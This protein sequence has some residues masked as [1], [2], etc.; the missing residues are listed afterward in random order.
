MPRSDAVWGIDIGQCA[1]KALRC[2]PHEDPHRV[3]ALAFDYIEFPKMLNQPDVDPAELIQDALAQFL[4]RNGVRGDRVVISVS[5]QSGLARFIKLPPVEAKKIPDIVRY[6]ARQQIPFALT[7]VVWDYQQMVG[8]TVVEG[9][10]M[11]TEVGL[12]A[13]K[14]DQVYRALKPF[15]AAGIEVDIVQLAPLALYNYVVFDQMPKLPPPDEYDADNPPESIVL[16]SLGT[17][18]TDLVITNGYRMWQRSIP[19]GG[20]HFTK[21]LTKELKLTFATAEHLKRNAAQ[22]EDPRALFQ[23]M[24]PVFND[25]LTEVQRSIGYFTNLHRKEKIGRCLALGNAMKLPGLQRYLSQNLGMDLERVEGYRCLSGTSVTEAPAFKENVMSFGVSYGLCLQALR[26]TRIRTNLLPREIL[27]DRL[28]RSK[29]PWA[30]GAAAALLLSLILSYFFH[31]RAWNAVVVPNYW[32]PA[33]AEADRVVAKANGYKTEYE[34]AREAYKK[35]DTAGLYLIQNLEGRELWIELLKALNECL[36][37][38]PAGENL[39]FE[40]RREIKITRIECQRLTNLNEWWNTVKDVYHESKR[41]KE[42]VAA[43]QPAAPAVDEPEKRAEVLTPGDM[44]RAV[45][46]EGLMGKDEPPAAEPAQTTETPPAAPQVP[47]PSGPGW[48]FQITGYHYHNPRDDPS[49]Q[50]ADY[51]RKTLIAN[52]EQPEV[53]GIDVGRLGIGYPVLV[54]V[55][56]IDFN[57]QLE[58]PESEFTGEGAN[59]ALASLQAAPGS[60][61]PNADGK[62]R[63]RVARFDF[64]LQFCWVETPRHKRGG[65]SAPAVAAVANAPAPVPLGN[66]NAANP[67]PNA[68]TA[69]DGDDDADASTDEAA[70]EGLPDTVAGDAAP[71][72]ETSDD[73]APDDAAETDLAPDASDDA[74]DGEADGEADDEADGEA[75]DEADSEASD[76]ASPAQA[77]ADEEAE[78][79]PPAQPVPDDEAPE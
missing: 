37:R 66:P 14:R 31:W 74:A 4:S 41:T 79:G 24:R 58:V 35:V 26:E 28:I 47:G 76:D 7:D 44:K 43:L 61:G 25:L 38:S 20:S 27:Q 63:V 62:R 22:A 18:T 29:K 12:F 13:M 10:V 78:A 70:G 36:P 3:V 72:A 8:G 45:G 33:A 50:G 51:V 65:A 16:L 6:E 40:R 64:V 73:S 55:P 56:N 60:G 49:N 21:A 9:F 15:T 68:A 23:A 46:A 53:N 59:P 5:G 2:R 39:P 67:A 54:H 77:A 48:V 30:V 32:E 19:L 52:L 34:Q 75:D 57:Y 1:L 69:D 17:D 11:E 42:Q 71:D